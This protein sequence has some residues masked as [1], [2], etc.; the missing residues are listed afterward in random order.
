[1]RPRRSSHV[2]CTNLTNDVLAHKDDPMTC[3]PRLRVSSCITRQKVRYHLQQIES[4]V[5]FDAGVSL[6]I[7][8]QCHRK[9]GLVM[10]GLGAS[11]ER[12]HSV[13]FGCSP[14]FI[15]GTPRSAGKA[16]TI[17][18]EEHCV[19]HCYCCRSCWDRARSRVPVS[20]IHLDNVRNEWIV[21]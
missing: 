15:P 14:Q 1:M 2:T 13:S 4:I 21:V 16:G 3:F 5:Y 9:R 11:V 7:D 10:L 19:V 12:L 6:K 20:R 17:E 18:H 8:R